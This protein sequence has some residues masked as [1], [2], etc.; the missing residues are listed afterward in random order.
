MGNDVPM[1]RECEDAMMTE[2]TKHVIERM[3]VD[4]VKPSDIGE[5][6]GYHVS[7]VSKAA[8]E[9]G[10]A[11]RRKA[12]RFSEKQIRKMV[13]MRESGLTYREI[14]DRFGIHRSLARYYVLNWSEIIERQRRQNTSVCGA[15]ETE[16][17][18]IVYDSLG[19]YCM[20]DKLHVIECTV[21]GGTY[22]Y[23]NGDYEYCPR[24]GRRRVWRE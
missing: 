12:N 17:Y 5:C 23:V 3:W 10:L 19:K 16:T 21:C 24:C 22:E 4:G 2:G 20:R 8:R 9:L 1:R 15:D 18:D 6:V 14:G 13:E 11:P 7:T